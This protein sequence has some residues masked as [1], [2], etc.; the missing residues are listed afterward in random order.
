MALND[1]RRISANRNAF[2]HVRVKSP[3]REK[4]VGTVSATG[5]TRCGEFARLVLS[6][7][8]KK[9]FRRVLKHGDEFVADDFSFPLGIG[10]ALERFQKTLGGV[11]IFQ[12]NM[13]V[14]AE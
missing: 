7:L 5:R 4:F 3:L 14:F 6:I 8:G 9:F 11:D 13:K 12:T 2:D 10:Y 1:G